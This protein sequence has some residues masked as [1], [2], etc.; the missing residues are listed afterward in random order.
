LLNAPL[1]H[2]AI[3]GAPVQQLA[4]S[5]SKAG[6]RWL[7]PMEQLSPLSWIVRG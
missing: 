2:G 7:S 4:I 5:R 1:L 3:T 6:D